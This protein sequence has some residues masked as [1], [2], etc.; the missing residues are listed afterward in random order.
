[1]KHT[2]PENL[3]SICRDVE[4]NWESQSIHTLFLERA[5]MAERLDVAANV[6]LRHRG[7]AIADA[8]L[9][10]IEKMMMAALF[11]NRTTRPSH[12]WGRIL[13]V[14]LLITFGVGVLLFLLLRNNFF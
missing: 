3:L 7:E 2:I 4:K 8:Q 1:M 6:Y 14:I 11:S 9:E 5:L 10:S 13:T 12:Q